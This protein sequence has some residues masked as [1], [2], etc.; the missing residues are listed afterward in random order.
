MIIF[1]QGNIYSKNQTL[2]NPESPGFQFGYGFFT[3][4]KFEEEKVFFL[5]KHLKRLENSLDQFGLTLPNLDYLNIIKSMI[6]ESCLE[7]GRVKIIVYM[8]HDGMSEAVIFLK[9]NGTE[10]ESC[11]LLLSEEKRGDSILWKHKSLSYLS[12]FLGKKEAVLQGAD[13]FLYKDYRDNLLETSI[14]N[15]FFI[16]GKNIYT[17]PKSLPILPGIIREE[18]LEKKEIDGFH[19]FEKEIKV[20]EISFFDGV[21]LTNSIV[22]VLPVLS[23]NEIQFSSENSKK[24]KN[25]IL[26]KFLC[27]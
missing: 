6:R 12:L 4:M 8:N 26:Q 15:I 17:P 13:D 9:E 14:A 1:Y 3:T 5:Q 24:I 11:R 16:Q 23:I 18:I 25:Q 20:S 19:I 22:P 21:F 7:K 27:P 2:I 10:L